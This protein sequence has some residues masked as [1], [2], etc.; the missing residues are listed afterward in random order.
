[1]ARELRVQYPGAIYHVMNRGDR[2]EAIFHDLNPARAGLIAP[3][4]P[5]QAYLWSS[6]P[7]YLRE[8]DRR[9]QWLRVNR[10]M[11]EWGIPTDSEAGRE[12]FAARMEARRQAEGADGFEPKGWCLGSEEFRHELLAQVGQLAS[13]K[14]AGEEI[15]QSALAK[16]QRIAQEELNALGWSA[17]E[18]Q[19]RRKSDPQKI[20]IAARL[21][22]E[23]TMTLEWIASRLKMGAPTHVA[24]LLQRHSQKPQNSEKTLF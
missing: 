19:G 9:P 3:Q 5:L 14:H 16:A 10:L 11:G 7:L 24:S 13:P 15:R 6:Y 12:Q 2:R 23:T 20:R 17:E 22:H 8:P 18:L 4:Q 1:M 21:R